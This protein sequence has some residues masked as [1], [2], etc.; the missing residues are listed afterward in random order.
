[1]FLSRLTQLIICNRNSYIE[2]LQNVSMHKVTV[3]STPSCP[4]CH[5]AKEWLKEH[6][7]KFKDVDVSEDE[8]ARD[9][10]VNKSG[11]T[12]VPQIEVDGEVIVG[13]DVDAL[14]EMLLD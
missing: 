14:S 9:Y 4:W 10:I 1:M 3:Y 6:K 12:G 5:K 2:P 7:I 8:A 13:F 11:Q